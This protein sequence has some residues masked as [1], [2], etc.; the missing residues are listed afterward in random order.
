MSDF[1]KVLDV[2]TYQAGLDPAKAWAAGYRAV[3]V[4]LGGDNIKPRYVAPHYNEQ[5]DK[6]RKAGFI[7]GH[8]WVPGG[9]PVGAADFFV[10]HLRNLDKAKDFLVLDNETLDDG[11]YFNDAQAATW[12]R[13][14]EKRSG[15]SHAQMF[16]YV[17]QSFAAERAWPL[18]NAYNPKIIV[19]VYGV[20]DGKRHADPNTG[21]VFT[22]SWTGHQ[23]TSVGRI[24][25]Y[26]GNLDLNVFKAGSLDFAAPAKPAPTPAPKPEPKP[27]PKPTTWTE[28]KVALSLQTWA[29]KGGYVGPLDGKLGPNSWKGIQTNL[30]KSYGYDG[31]IDGEP[32]E[33]TYTALQ[34][35]A[36]KGGYTGPLD[37]I[38]G[39]NSWHGVAKA[40]G[41]K[42][43]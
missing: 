1:I 19:A 14:V 13:E 26:N 30:H 39:T 40:L 10:R 31:P 6:F 21:H 22:H 5:V 4:K 7:I 27:T 35:L 41:Q 23:F 37:G 42:N 9:D 36:K 34:R 18:V 32:G 24:E 11:S 25:G 20:N 16:M 17:G 38:M 29:R 15:V 3:Y 8:Y 33:H 43:A 12:L 28:A 2:S